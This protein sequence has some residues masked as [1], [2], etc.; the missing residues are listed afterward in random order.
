MRMEGISHRM[1]NYLCCVLPP[2]FGIALPGRS[3]RVPPSSWEGCEAG[4]VLS[5]LPPML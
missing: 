4:E 3:D 5:Q 1:S 2:S